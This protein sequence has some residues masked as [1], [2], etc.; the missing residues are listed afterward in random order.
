MLCVIANRQGRDRCAVRGALTGP[1]PARGGVARRAVCGSG[2]CDQARAR[3]G[4]TD[5]KSQIVSAAGNDTVASRRAF[6]KPTRHKSQHA[7]VH[8][9]SSRTYAIRLT[10]GAVVTP[11]RLRGATARARPSSLEGRGGPGAGRSPSDTTRPD[12]PLLTLVATYAYLNDT[13]IPA[14]ATRH[15]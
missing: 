10:S 5:V 6:V 8:E 14:S 1:A 12:T 4:R 15:L 9:E 7:P 11:A 2:R 13:A 3:S